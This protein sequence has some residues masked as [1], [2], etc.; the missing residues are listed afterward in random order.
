ME[1]SVGL[2][3]V[4]THFDDEI[5][6]SELSAEI[7][8]TKEQGYFAA[9]TRLVSGYR[10]KLGGIRPILLNGAATRPIRRASSSPTPRSSAP[11]AT[12]SPSALSTCGSIEPS[13]PASTRI[14]TSLIRTASRSPSTS[15]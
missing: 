10:L 5:V 8:S 2:P 15:R 13:V 11:T 6:V 9:D 7:S 3:V 1:V 14:T 12:R 4:S